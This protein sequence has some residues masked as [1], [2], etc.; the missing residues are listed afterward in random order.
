M[1]L[2]EL[3]IG[4]DGEIYYKFVQTPVQWYHILD[5]RQWRIVPFVCVRKEGLASVASVIR[6]CINLSRARDVAGFPVIRGICFN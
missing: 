6:T 1:P 3:N 4:I 5:P 2:R